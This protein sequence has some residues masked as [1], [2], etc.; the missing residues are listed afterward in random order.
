MAGAEG[1]VKGFVTM[2]YWLI[3][4]IFVRYYVRNTK[5]M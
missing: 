3:D 1:L 5:A 4:G 2:G